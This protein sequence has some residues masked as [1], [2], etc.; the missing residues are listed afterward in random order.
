MDSVIQKKYFIGKSKPGTWSSVYTY[1]PSSQTTRDKRGEI[2]AAICLEGPK[3]YGLPTV[4]NMLLDK[5]HE[6]YFENSQDSCLISVEK[7]SIEIGK[8]LQKFLENDSAGNAGIDLNFIALVIDKDLAYVVKI[9][10]GS[11]LIHRDGQITDISEILKDPT[12]EGLVKEA[13]FVTKGNDVYFIGTP[14]TR[15]ELMHKE[16]SDAAN[17][18]NEQ[19]LRNHLYKDESQI[20]FMMVG[21]NIDRKQPELSNQIIKE[22]NPNENKIILGNKN[23]VEI[24]EEAKQEEE[25]EQIKESEQV[26]QNEG[27]GITEEVGK[28]GDENNETIADLLSK[29]GAMRDTQLTGKHFGQEHELLNENDF[30]DGNEGLETKDVE[31]QES[32]EYSKQEPESEIESE[33]ESNEEKFEGKD[34][35]PIQTSSSVPTITPPTISPIIP[36]IIPPRPGMMVSAKGSIGAVGGG[37]ISKIKGLFKKKP[38]SEDAKGEFPKDNVANTFSQ[39]EDLTY[40]EEA[41]RPALTTASRIAKQDLKTYQVI[42]LKIK[43]FIINLLKGIK[44]LVWNNWLGFNGDDLYLKSAAAKQRKWGLLIVLVL[45]V[46]ALLYFSIQ[47]LIENQNLKKIEDT[48]KLHLDAGVK[49]VTDVNAQADLLAKASGSVERKAAE[50]VKL[51]N[52]QVELD[53]AK[54][55][56]KFVEEATR[57]EQIIQ[58]IK[59]KFDRVIP[60]VELNYLVDFAGKFPNANITDMVVLNNFIYVID[61]KYNKLYS[62]NYSGVVTEVV[63]GLN[64]PRSITAD[65]KG[66]LIILDSDNDKSIAFVDPIAKT[67]TRMSATSNSKLSGV[68]QIEFYT[69]TSNESRIY[70]LNNSDKSIGYYSRTGSNYGTY[71]KRNSLEEFATAKDMEIIDDRLYFL[72]Q[73]NIGLYR[74]LGK[75]EDAINVTGMKIGETLLS[76][77]AL[78]V[79][80]TNV[81]VGDPSGKR[82]LVFTKGTPEIP[83]IAQYV[84][85]GNDPSIFTDFK[86]IYTD[87]YNGKLFVLANSKVF[88]LDLKALDAFKL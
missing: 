71:I 41:T 76:A 4:G 13:S 3:D 5:F 80:G 50:L 31:V 38:K 83:L 63:S 33:Q 58:S 55:V 21:V 62:I 75:K 72:M 36:T 81:Y 27:I 39:R 40:E 25:I 84:Y 49:I 52:A 9:G 8:Y 64:N 29:E 73:K 87:S 14:Q 28:E 22:E 47:G 45:V 24:S 11:L 61:A 54:T 79:D 70:L 57:Q 35:V 60:L 34:D 43:D 26:E 65:D 77:T 69:L 48:A 82:I 30:E 2:F 67:I 68:S 10:N 88:V 86:E 56:A 51:D 74:D 6:T 15:T 59:D 42:L 23:K 16:F 20:A 66:I 85:K 37:L 7:A 32:E 1:K 44:K 18:F 46:A 12:L 78:Y 19:S 17:Q 53:L